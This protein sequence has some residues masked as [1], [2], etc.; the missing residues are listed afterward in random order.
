MPESATVFAPR[1]RSASGLLLPIKPPIPMVPEV[2]EIENAWAPSTV[3]VIVT[4][5]ALDVRVAFAPSVIGPE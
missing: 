1:V 3:P 4:S 5:S 2:A